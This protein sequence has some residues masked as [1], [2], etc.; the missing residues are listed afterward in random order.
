MQPVWTHLHR[1]PEREVRPGVY[2]RILPMAQMM[3][4]GVR[5]APH[6][7]VPTHQHPHE[8]MGIVLE[9]ELDLWI[10]DE[11]RTLRRGDMYAIPPNV[12]HG[13][14]TKAS[15]CLVLDVFHPLREDYIALFSPA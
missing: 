2:L 10:G 9:G 5:F 15:T 14:E 7:T 12:P 3:F 11:R 6:A 1:L 4:S 8:Q 13:A